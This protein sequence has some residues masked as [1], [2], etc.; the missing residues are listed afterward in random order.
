MQFASSGGGLG[1]DGHGVAVASGCGVFFL[2]QFLFRFF[3][4]FERDRGTW[5]GG[6]HGTAVCPSVWPPPDDPVATRDA[7]E[8]WV[9][10]GMP[11][12]RAAD[13][14]VSSHCLHV[15]TYD[16]DQYEGRNQSHH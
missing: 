16:Q 4:R 7:H 2:L 13:P 6:H 12:A 8:C 3:D 9:W 15:L 14:S 10:P 5:I 1:T 11:E